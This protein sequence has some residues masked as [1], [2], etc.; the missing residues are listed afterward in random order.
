MAR[1]LPPQADLDHLKNEAKALHK[2]H[3]KREPD[4]CPVLRHIHRFAEASDEDIL[5]AEVSL[6]EAQFALAMEYGFN[7]WQQLRKTVIGLKPP[8]G[9]VPEAYGDAMI[10]PNPPAGIS[11]ANRFAAA[12]SI[13]MSYLGAPADYE[14]VAGDSGL[15]FIL[16][17]DSIHKPFGANVEPL[18]MGWWPLAPWGSRLRLDFL[19]ATYGIPMHHAPAVQPEWKAD[20]G[21]SPGKAQVAEYKADPAAYY[22]KHL[23]SQVIESLRAGRPVIATEDCAHV[24][25]GWDGGSPPLLGQVSCEEEPNVQRMDMFPFE[26]IVLDEPGEPGDR[27]QADVEA[28]DF[29]VRLGRDE[30]DLSH[31]P[32][33]S[34][35]RRSWELWAQQLADDR[36]CGPH[37]YHA[38]VVW[39]LR[40]NRNVVPAYLRRMGARHPQPIADPLARAA[41]HYDAVKDLLRQMDTSE[42]TL[43]TTQGRDTL[44]S[45][46]RATMDLE[47]RAQDEMAEALTALVMGGRR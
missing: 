16:Q 20:P 28:L 19:A 33:K 22:R 2:A 46:I 45:V 40:I 31:L 25:F 5:A 26:V 8:P 11:P 9:Y 4:V 14:T 36:L 23:E 12:Y 1:F 29:A 43:S 30:V 44:I 21:A 32:G 47:A 15:G 7:S 10:L 27:H 42:N 6:T 18:D 39:N 13:A 24:V 41:D 34:S 37:F 35:G 38:N 3:K 17:A